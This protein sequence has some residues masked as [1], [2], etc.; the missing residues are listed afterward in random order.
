M[1]KIGL[2]IILILSII[3]CKK[4][5]IIEVISPPKPVPELAIPELAIIDIR[6]TNNQ[7]ITSKN[8]Y[9][10]GQLS[11]SGIKKYEKLNEKIR[12]K[13]RGNSTW[14]YPKK[15]YHIEFVNS[16]SLFS[17]ETDKDWLLIANY[18]DDNHIL[19]AT[20]F[21]I[22]DA[23]QMPYTSKFIPVE[24]NINGTYQGLYLLTEQIEKE[25]TRVNI[26][27]AG[28]ILEMDT[29]FNDENKFRSKT[30]NLPINIKYPKT[31]DATKLNKI[32][33]DFD[34]ME[35]NVASSD[36]PNTNYA[37]LIDTESLCNYLI[38]YYLT[39]NQEINH[40]KSIF[41]HKNSTGKFQMG[42][43]WDFDWAYSYQF[44]GKH[45]N[46]ATGDLF[47]NSP[48][49]G[50]KFYQRFLK[51]PKVKAQF[52]LKWNEFRSKKF[53]SIIEFVDVYSKLLSVARQRD[54]NKWNKN[55]KDYSNEISNMKTWLNS[56]AFFIDNMVKGW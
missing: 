1:K 37:D 49:S 2:Y 50:T 52:K 13:G 51:D 7:A 5:E 29:Y 53:E 15:P 27:E 20:A 39:D 31:V 54:I 24:V 34:A 43:V 22:A 41:M 38:V 47:W 18:L 42:P 11:I 23:L 35:S 56:K 10:E 19:N 40:P 8:T 46:S 17:L 33:L 45:F 4:N 44:S 48:S 25:K 36:F 9:I 55:P 26:D 32:K 28:M 14:G 16:V 21:T 6:T 3:S 12:I 30:Y